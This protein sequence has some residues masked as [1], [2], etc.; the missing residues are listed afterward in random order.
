[1]SKKLSQSNETLQGIQNSNQIVLYSP[2]DSIS[3]EVRLENETVWLTQQQIAQL[4]GVKRPAITKFLLKN[5]FLF[6]LICKL[7]S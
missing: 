6:I 7:Y 3:L 5:Y 2:N 4:C 1:M